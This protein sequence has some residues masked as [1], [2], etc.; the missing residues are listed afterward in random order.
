M[1]RPT[2][3]TIGAASVLVF[4]GGCALEDVKPNAGTGGSGGAGVSGGSAGSVPAT[5]GVGGSGTPAG[6][7]NGAGTSP[8]GSLGA[9]AGDTSTG[10][11]AAG[12]GPMGGAGGS[13]AGTGGTGGMGGSAGMAGASPGGTGGVAG[14]MPSGGQGGMMS[15]DLSPN[16]IVP[17]L[18][19]YLWVGTCSSAGTGLDCAI[20]NDSNVCPGTSAS[21]A[22]SMR[23]AFRRRT[24]AVMGTQGRNYRLSFEL[25]GV[26]GGKNY[27]GGTRGPNATAFN[28]AAGV[29]ND[30]WYVGGTPTDSLWNTYEIHVTPGVTGQANVYYAN[31][32]P[33]GTG[34]GWHGT[35][36]MRIVT[37][38]VVP[39]GGS[40]E[41]VIH[42][43]NCQ[44]QQNCGPTGD[45]RSVCTQGAG[46][47]T[48][49]VS[50]M[51]PQPTNFSQP[52]TQSNGLHPQWLLWDVKTVAVE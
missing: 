32:F 28:E 25:R 8:G 36:P 5:G 9:A 47:R 52:Y 40:I 38:V 20:N 44:G 42:D 7:V 46:P 21:T 22:Y 51:D 4:V 41:L 49:D 14:A 39:A 31:G 11:A 1:K 50:G 37:S 29:N 33:S 18:D 24:F 48:V 16:A 3:I 12:T 17:G 43:S 6:G 10:G 27:M 23:G 34:D 15:E 26:T 35:V 45:S 30:G 2:S 13:D 19:G